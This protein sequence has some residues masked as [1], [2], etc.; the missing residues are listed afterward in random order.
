MI[1]DR[2]E[3][4]N[5]LVTLFADDTR[6]EVTSLIEDV[7]DSW[8][9]SQ[10]TGVSQEEYDTL[11]EKYNASVKAYRERFTQGEPEEVEEV[12]ETEAEEVEETVVKEI[13]DLFE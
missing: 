3:V 13:D 8:T 10:P 6:E 9:E 5:S 2:Q 4:I 7:S 11:Q 12:E 1:R